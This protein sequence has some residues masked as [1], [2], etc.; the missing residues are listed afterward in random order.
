MPSITSICS[1]TSRFSRAFSFS[2]SLSRLA[3]GPFIPPNWF[4]QRWNVV[5]LTPSPLQTSGIEAP[6]LGSNIE[7]KP[8]VSSGV[9]TDLTG[10]VPVRNDG[11]ADAG[12]DLEEEIARVSIHGTLHVLGY[13]HPE[14]EE[15][16][17]SP[18]WERQERLLARLARGARA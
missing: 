8:Y 11:H 17:A 18:M 1:A 2:N 16:L 13:D 3:S 9:S 12:V 14:G 10:T 5:S 6:P 4:R 15:R 7:I